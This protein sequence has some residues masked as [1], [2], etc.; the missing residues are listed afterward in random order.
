MSN[1]TYDITFRIKKTA[2]EYINR[3]EQADEKTS[4][5]I[6][7]S[8][9]FVGETEDLKFKKELDDD[10]ST[11]LEHKKVEYPY[12]EPQVQDVETI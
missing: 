5:N 2:L 1:L 11:D 12:V 7:D 10:L 8:F 4:E 3:K 6:S 9:G